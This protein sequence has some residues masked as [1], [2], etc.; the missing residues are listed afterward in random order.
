MIKTTSNPANT[1][2]YRRLFWSI[3]ILFLSITFFDLKKLNELVLVP[4]LT[5]TTFL[6]IR[7]FPV[8]V[9]LRQGCQVLAL[10]A[11]SLGI[12]E[13]LIPESTLQDVFSL[14]SSLLFIVFLAIAI[15]VMS[16]HL[17]HVDSVDADT[18]IGGISVYLLLG[19]WWSLLYMVTFSLNPSAFKVLP[20]H[21]LNPEFSLLYFSFTTLTTLGYGDIS[22]S[23]PVSMGLAN[24][25]AVLGQLYPAV[26]IARLVSLYAVKDNQANFPD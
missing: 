17:M 12:F 21:D 24:L 3:I 26:L 6:A 8:P 14:L 7:T 16:Y 19:V 10:L 2:R 1:R 25:E 15:V 9:R 23:G 11:C 13:T 22:P 4:L 20:L 5:I 18:V